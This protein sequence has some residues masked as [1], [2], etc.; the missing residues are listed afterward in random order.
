M[1]NVAE[2]NTV[3][4]LSEVALHEAMVVFKTTFSKEAVCLIVG[5]GYLHTDILKIIFS[6][7]GR[8]DMPFEVSY[9]LG[10]SA[11]ILTDG[12]CIVYSPGV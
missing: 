7:R 2:L 6:V 11:W 4:D 10:R 5:S 9:A 12:E 8:L 1:H 3:M